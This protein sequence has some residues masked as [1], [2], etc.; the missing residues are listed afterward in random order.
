[1]D[2]KLS[3]KKSEY[4]VPVLSNLSVEQ[5]IN[6]GNV[7]VVV[8]NNSDKPAQFVE[9]YALFFD[10]NNNIVSTTNTYVGDDDSEIKSGAT[11]SAQ[12]DTFESFD[13]VE[14]YFR[15]RAEK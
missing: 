15:G 13:H 8:T 14:C 6:D 7:T 12:L 5:N 9:A 11:L 2:C 1:M 3:Y 4:Y 10:S